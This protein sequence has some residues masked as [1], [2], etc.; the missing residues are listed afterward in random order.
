MHRHRPRSTAIATLAAC[1]VGAAV[2]VAPTSV[3]AEPTLSWAACADPGLKKAGVECAQLEVPMDRDDPSVGVVRLA[4]VRHKSSGSAAE[5]I[6]SLVFNPGGPGGSGVQS[7]ASVWGILPA[8][9]KRH[10]DLVSWGPRGVNES[11]PSLSGC[12]TPYPIRPVTG[13]I[14]WAQV[15]RQFSRDLG[16]ANRACQRKNATIIQHM[17]TVE[18]VYDLDRIRA[19]LGEDQLTYWGMSYGT[20]IGYVYA[21]LFPDRMRAFVLD[22]SIDPAGTQIGLAQGGAG[23]DQAYGVFADAYPASD[24]QLREVLAVLDERTIAL[25]DGSTLDRWDVR[26]FVFGFDAQQA[27]YPAIAQIIG[28]WHAAIFAAGE[29]Q[30]A[31]LASSAQVAAQITGPNSNAG[32]VFSAVNCLDYAGRPSVAQAIGAIRYQD[33]LAPQYGGSLSTMYALGCSGLAIAPDPVPVITGEGP[34]VPVLILGASRDGSTVN[35]WTSRMSRAFP[36]SRTVT[37]AGGQHVTWGTV[38][39]SCV[40]KAANTFVIS[41]RLPAMDVGCSNTLVP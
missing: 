40:N 5:R 10:F 4:V 16:V 8:A 31:A 7:I 20:R 21:L 33:R 38:H 27:A 29:E 17:S 25:P 34:R 28:I 30:S 3:A 23:P 35:Q 15:A 19:A 32:A 12:A 9:V 36:T 13:P 6:G 11:T 1:F 22:G 41:L 37:Y 26:D 14:D 18:N 39:S 24:Q 2:L